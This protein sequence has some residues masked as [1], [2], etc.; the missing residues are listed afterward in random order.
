[1]HV[2]DSAFQHCNYG[3]YLGGYDIIIENTL[4]YG[5]WS[6]AMQ[7]YV[8]DFA[9][10]DRTI[11]RNNVV[12]YNQHFQADHPKAIRKDCPGPNILF[13]RGRDMQI[14]NNVFVGGGKEAPGYGGGMMPRPRGLNGGAN[15]PCLLESV[16]GLQISHAGHLAKIYNNTMTDNLGPAIRVQNFIQGNQTAK[17]IFYNNNGGNVIFNEGNNN[18]ITDVNNLKGVN[19][20]FVNAPALNFQLS[21]N[22]PARDGATTLGAP[23]NV[24]AN[25]VSRP[26]AGTS[27][28]DYGACE[29]FAGAAVCPRLNGVQPSPAN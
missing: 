22:S 27:R 24:D 16:A 18:E 10:I 4:Y 1:L 29:W 2:I 11:F 23:Y 12:A 21:S 9:G 7:H 14:Y 13:A 6:Y 3:M 17:N 5:N 25:G 15:D 19:P 26:A 28:W 8:E 20:L